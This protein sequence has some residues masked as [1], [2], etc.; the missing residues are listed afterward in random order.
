MISNEGTLQKIKLYSIYHCIT[1]ADS[2]QS[3]DSS[4][5]YDDEDD[6]EERDRDEEE[7][8]LELVK[9]IDVKP[10]NTLHLLGDWEKHTTVSMYVYM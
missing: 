4:D 6:N 10:S 3:D 1:H 7:E 5:S 8:R 9:I 2:D